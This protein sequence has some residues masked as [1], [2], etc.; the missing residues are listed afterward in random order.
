MTTADVAGGWGGGGGCRAECVLC[1]YL[2][3][4]GIQFTL[5]TVHYSLI[6]GLCNQTPSKYDIKCT[7][8]KFSLVVTAILEKAGW[9]S[10]PE[11]CQDLSIN[12]PEDYLVLSTDERGG[13]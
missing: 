9:N 6:V 7:S 3:T 4:S 11:G 5:C 1:T 13:L 10:N 12:S 2:C 8:L